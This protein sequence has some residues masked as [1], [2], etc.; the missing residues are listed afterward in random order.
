M[1]T[2]IHLLSY[3]ARFFLELEMFQSEVVEKI[4][5]QFLYSI[6]FFENR[7]VYEIMWKNIVERGRPQITIRRMRIGCWIRKATNAHNR[8]LQ[9][10]LLFHC[11]YGCTNTP[12]YYFIRTLPVFL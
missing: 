9:Y 12:Q 7:A 5:T 3:L 11:N 8:P 6:P 4:K 2:N 1:K 10:S